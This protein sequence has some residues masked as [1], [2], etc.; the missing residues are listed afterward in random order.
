MAIT[1]DQ[2][3]DERKAMGEEAVGEQQRWEKDSCAG[4]SETS[5]CSL[6][7]GYCVGASNS[8]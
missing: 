3:W 2:E 6:Q 4:A 8:G 7:P 1:A 5:K